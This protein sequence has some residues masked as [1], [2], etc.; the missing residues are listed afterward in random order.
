MASD[1]AMLF[2]LIVSVVEGLQ[3]ALALI[4]ITTKTR[5]DKEVSDSTTRP[6]LV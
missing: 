5:R 6:S 2:F 4:Q 1:V 3:D